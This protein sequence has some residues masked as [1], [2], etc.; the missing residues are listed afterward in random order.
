MKRIQMARS[1]WARAAD[2]RVSA[3]PMDEVRIALFVLVADSHAFSPSERQTLAEFI[4][5]AGP[6]NSSFYAAELAEEL[7]ELILVIQPDAAPTDRT[8][9]VR[10]ADLVGW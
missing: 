2:V 7:R 6:R 4:R 5:S 9:P 1:A 10:L 8:A 3:R